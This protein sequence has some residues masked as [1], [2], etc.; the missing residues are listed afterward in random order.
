MNKWFILAI[1][2]LGFSMSAFASSSWNGRI[3]RVPTQQDISM[4]E[5]TAGLSKAQVIILGEKHNTSAI[6][7]AQ[8]LIIHNVV[9]ATHQ[10]NQFLTAWEFLN[11]PEQDKINLAYARFISGKID[12]LGF[13]IETQGTTN[14]ASYIPILDITKILQGNLIG[15][16]I[17][18]EAKQPVVEGGIGAVDP[19]YLPPDFA[20]GST[21]YHQRFIDIMTGHGSPE[22]IENY[23]AAQCLTDDIMAYTLQKNFN[24]PLQ[25]LITGSFHTDYFDGVVNRI[26]IRLPEKSVIVVRLIDASEYDE[27]ELNDMLPDILYDKTYGNIADYVYF[28]NETMLV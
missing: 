15:V 2:T 22:R 9:T 11:Y 13:L 4:K 20:M 21:G 27:Q 14:N 23:Y 19:Q 8:S 12:G 7:Y 17:S 26:K 24:I 18:R 28:V 1:L 3:I 25:F 5:L 10:E 6:Q 16:N